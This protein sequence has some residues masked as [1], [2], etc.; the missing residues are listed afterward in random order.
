MWR[1]LNLAFLKLAPHFG[2]IWSI[3]SD[4]APDVIVELLSTRRDSRACDISQIFRCVTVS[5][6]IHDVCE[7]CT[8]I[9]CCWQ[10]HK[11]QVHCT[12]YSSHP[13]PY[14]RFYP[15]V[16]P[17][18]LASFLLGLCRIISH[19]YQ[20]GL[21]DDTRVSALSSSYRVL[22]V[23]RPKMVCWCHIGI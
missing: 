12:R 19:Q 6:C 23:R 11:P 16:V 9:R 20:N 8:T 2:Q 17:C 1:Y 22:C 7:I 18:N 14:I 5:R 13:T 21:V 15:R 4:E 3:V 10:R